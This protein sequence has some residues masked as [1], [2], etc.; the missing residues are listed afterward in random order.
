MGSPLRPRH[1]VECTNEA[2]N[3]SR[4]LLWAPLT[5][6][7]LP[8]TPSA[9]LT[10]SCCSFLSLGLDRCCSFCP[11][12]PQ[13]SAWLTPSRSLLG[14]PL[15]RKTF[16]FPPR[17]QAR[18]HSTLPWSTLHFLIRHAF[19]TFTS[20]RILLALKRELHE[21]GGSRLRCSS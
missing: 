2:K 1:A 14:C 15:L 9:P 4:P 5:Y 3:S 8:P 21:G 13:R 11:H 20:L 19:Y 18:S 6:L 12:C 7:Q 16:P 10:P 17:F